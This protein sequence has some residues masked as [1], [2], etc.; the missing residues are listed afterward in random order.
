MGCVAGRGIFVSN[1]L[2]LLKNFSEKKWL[3]YIFKIEK[4]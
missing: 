1:Y 4:E 3:I 2:I